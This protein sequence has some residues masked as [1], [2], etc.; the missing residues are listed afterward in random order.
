MVSTELLIIVVSIFVLIKSSDIFIENIAKLAKIFKVS[1]FIIGLT[2]VAAG[3]SLPELTAAIFAA[4]IFSFVEDKMLSNNFEYQKTLC[5]F[6]FNKI[7]KN[8]CYLSII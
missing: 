2:I 1:D 4:T 5:Q 3:T 7:S 8:N 6:K